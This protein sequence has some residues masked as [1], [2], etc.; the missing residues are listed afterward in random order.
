MATLYSTQKPHNYVVL[1]GLFVLLTINNVNSVQA[2]SF[3]FTQFADDGSLTL[4]GDA[5]IWTD[6]SLALPT[7]PS[8]NWTT[9]RVLFA[10]PVPIWDSTTGYEASFITSFSFVVK[11]FKNFKPA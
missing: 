11:D 10:T 4:Q 8:F 6:G 5:K 1:A 2:V 3:N 9:S 7:D